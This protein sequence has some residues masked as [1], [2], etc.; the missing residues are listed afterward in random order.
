M[1][2][3]YQL[4]IKRKWETLN[5]KISKELRNI[6]HGYIMSDGYVNK[7]GYLQIDQSAQQIKFVQWLYDKL[8]SLRTNTPISQVIRID[9]RTNKKT[10]S[11]RFHTRN[12]LKGFHA[13]WYK[14][15]TDQKGNTKYQK[16]L[17][18]S[19]PCFFDSTFITLWFAGDGTKMINQRGAKLEVTSFSPEE[20]KQLQVLFKKKFNISVK[21]NRAGQSKSGKEQWS[22][23]IN[24]GEYEKFRELITQ[25]D[26]IPTLFSYK[27][28]SVR[29][30]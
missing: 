15:Y 7:D 11:N 27:L 12:L 13:M 6:I 29:N 2:K 20:R 23:C 16:C 22:L 19:F 30:S 24:S 5:V 25:M 14:P 18:T 21:I 10:Y 9:K 17:P 8:E 4:R 26:L 3:Y 28:N 1:E